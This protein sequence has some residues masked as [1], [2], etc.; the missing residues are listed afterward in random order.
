MKIL[1]IQGTPRT[2]GNTAAVLGWIEGELRAA[3]HEA[4]RV[5]VGDGGIRPCRG[6]DACKRDA[7][8]PACVQDDRANGIFADMISSDLVV[9]ASPLYCWGV[10]AQ[11]K[12]LLDR[13]YCLLKGADCGKSLIKG[14]RLA[15]AV[16][17][18][19]G[20]E[21][22]LDLAVA[23]FREFAKFFQCDNGGTLLVPDCTSPDRLGAGVEKRAREFARRLAS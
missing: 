9:L 13:C 6:C 1:C 3:G 22:N 23:P 2:K 11:L 7:D 20:F 5:E 15:L 19:G 16:T 4:K 18:G 21:D 8:R 14:K 12:S 17:G 10:C